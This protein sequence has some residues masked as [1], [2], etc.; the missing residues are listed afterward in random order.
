MPPIDS[1]PEDPQEA[2]RIDRH[3]PTVICVW[4]TRERAER[5]HGGEPDIRVTRISTAT[6]RSETQTTVVHGMLLE[7]VSNLIIEGIRRDRH[8]VRKLPPPA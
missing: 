3:R 8:P 4:A 6:S 1:P 5:P 7:S 2:L